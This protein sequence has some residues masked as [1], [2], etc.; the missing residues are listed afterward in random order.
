[1][2]ARLDGAAFGGQPVSS[3]DATALID[4]AN[5]LIAGATCP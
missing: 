4:Q 5:A 1:M 3:S 2:K